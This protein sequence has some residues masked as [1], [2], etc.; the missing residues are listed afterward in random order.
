MNSRPLVRRHHWIVRLTHWATV[1]LL[2]GMITSGL[3]IYEA[4]ARF[5]DKGSAAYV[6]PLEGTRFP[7]TVRLGGW[8]A[9][10]LNWHFALMWPLVAFGLLYMGY[11]A[12]SGE[13]RSLLFRPR[14]IPGAIQMMKYYLHLRKDHP[15]QGKHN[16]LQK[17]AYSS[18]VVL[19]VLAVLS[20]L[21]IYKPTQLGWLTA[22][23]GGFQL[24]RYWHFWIV[25]AFVA[26]SIVHVIL[27]FVVDPASLRAMLSGWYRGRF[28]SHD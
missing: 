5:G 21:S 22:L 15:A 25:W 1:L 18:V 16:P 27:V 2:A 8:L 23:F 12:A 9:G 19:G 17:L 7:A 20:G 3:Q 10:A 11:L 13:W 6:N 28:P 24:A 4:Y 26:F 14:D